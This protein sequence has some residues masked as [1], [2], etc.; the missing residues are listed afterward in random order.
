MFS[1]ETCEISLINAK[2]YRDGVNWLGSSVFTNNFKHI[3]LWANASVVQN[4]YFS[5]RLKNHILATTKTRKCVNLYEVKHQNSV[6]VVLVICCSSLNFEFSSF[7]SIS[8]SNLS[9]YFV[10]WSNFAKVK[11]TCSH[12]IETR[13]SGT[14]SCIF[15]E[16]MPWFKVK[17]VL[18]WQ[19]QLL[20]AGKYDRT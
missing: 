17:F 1:C 10:D 5:S 12:S 6:D 14:L 8:F 11:T 13:E 20:W 9:M 3:S 16:H 7:A 4:R 18:R 2:R 19:E 15:S